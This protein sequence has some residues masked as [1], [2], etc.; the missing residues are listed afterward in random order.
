MISEDRCK[1]PLVGKEEEEVAVVISME[2]EDKYKFL[3]EP[4]HTAVHIP[5]LTS[6][7]HYKHPEMINDNSNTSD[8]HNNDNDNLSALLQHLTSLL[9]S[10]MLE[11]CLIRK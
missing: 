6:S 4:V 11:L 10:N 7:E 3:E 5:T 9:M 1:F 2:C 8:N